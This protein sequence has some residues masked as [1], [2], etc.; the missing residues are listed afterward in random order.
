MCAREPVCAQ[1]QVQCNPPKRFRPFG[2]PFLRHNLE[3]NRIPEAWSRTN[4]NMH[5][6]GCMQ[7]MCVD[8]LRGWLCAG[9]HDFRWWPRKS[10]IK[11]FI[12]PMSS[13]TWSFLCDWMALVGALALP[14]HG[15]METVLDRNCM[16]MRWCAPRANVCI[17]LWEAHFL[18]FSDTP[19]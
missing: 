8:R 11:Y 9:T 1:H 19:A 4:G 14:L 10:V 3:A 13:R 18:S 6:F 12:S 5:A 16:R 15:H 2:E 7:A 17:L